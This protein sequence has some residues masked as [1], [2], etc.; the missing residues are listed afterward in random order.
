MNEQEGEMF[1]QTRGTLQVLGT[2]SES[3][4]RGGSQA[5]PPT[6]PW[7][8]VRLQTEVVGSSKLQCPGH[9]V[10]TKWV[11]ETATS[12]QTGWMVQIQV[13]GRS[14]GGDD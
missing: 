5:L 8:S 1:A 2:R 9:W 10:Y 7:Q 3:I 11:M 12:C 13:L 4:K 14:L 6:F